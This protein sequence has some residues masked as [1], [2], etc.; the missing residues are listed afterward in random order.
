MMYQAYAVARRH[1]PDEQRELVYFGPEKDRA[2][3]RIRDAIA[4]GFDYGYVKQGFDT[5][6]WYNERSFLSTTK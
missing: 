5:L 4:S 2:I 1:R 6:G 3:W